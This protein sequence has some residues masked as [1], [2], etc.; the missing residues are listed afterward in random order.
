MT[1]RILI[2]KKSNQ[3]PLNR[4][5]DN[6]IKAM[7]QHQAYVVSRN[8]MLSSIKIIELAARCDYPYLSRILK[9]AFYS[10]DD[11]QNLIKFFTTCGIDPYLDATWEG[12]EEMREVFDNT[13]EDLISRLNEEATLK[14]KDQG[15]IQ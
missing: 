5:I 1:K 8:Q 11:V 15:I 6:G 4:P 2:M 3:N 14:L 13:Y 12:Y 10:Y 9:D 7:L